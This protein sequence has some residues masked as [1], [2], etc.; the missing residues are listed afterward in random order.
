MVAAVLLLSGRPAPNSLFR[1]QLQ[2]VPTASLNEQSVRYVAPSM[3]VPAAARAATVPLTTIQ[4]A[5]PATAGATPPV[6]NAAPTV[7][8]PAVGM[9][10]KAS[11][12]MADVAPAQRKAKRKEK[13]IARQPPRYRV[14]RPVED[15]PGRAYAGPMSRYGEP[16]GWVERRPFGFGW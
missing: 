12:R 9:P 10:A 2:A 3:A 15:D 8:P 6:L 16:Y 4:A 11:G 5:A 13:K 7:T 1:M 14:A